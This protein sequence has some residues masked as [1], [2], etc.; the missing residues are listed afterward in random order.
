MR[1]NYEERYILEHFWV[2]LHLKME[3]PSK[4]TF[5]LSVG[6]KHEQSAYSK[7]PSDGTVHENINKIL[8]I[9]QQNEAKLYT[10]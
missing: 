9:Q 3:L 1:L 7:K 4:I 6:R 8:T 5:F 10:F 2:L